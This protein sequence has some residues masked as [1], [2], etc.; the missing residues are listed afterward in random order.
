MIVPGLGGWQK[1]AFVCV[2][3]FGSSL[4]GRKCI[5]K[6][7]RKPRDNPVQNVC[8]CFSLLWLFAPNSSVYWWS[9]V[10]NLTGVRSPLSTLSSGDFNKGFTPL[11]AKKGP[12]RHSLENP[13]LFSGD[14]A[15]R[16]CL[17]L[18][19][20]HGS[21]SHHSSLALPHLPSEIFRIIFLNFSLSSSFYLLTFTSVHL[22]AAKFSQF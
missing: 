2:C 8:M 18:D 12:F 14:P 5:N 3:V 11:I 22:I 20:H 6:I 4:L 9:L 7:R 15:C 13:S 16:R 1:Y 19:W 10:A 17:Q 21:D